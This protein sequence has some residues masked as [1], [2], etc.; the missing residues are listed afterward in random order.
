MFAGVEGRE[1]I[2]RDHLPD[3]RAGGLDLEEHVRGAKVD[4]GLVVAWGKAVPV[5]ELTEMVKLI[6]ENVSD[7]FGDSMLA[8]PEKPC[9]A[10]DIPG[11]DTSIKLGIKGVPVILYRMEHSHYI[12]KLSISVL[13]LKLEVLQHEHLH[14]KFSVS[15]I[16]DP[17]Y[18]LYILF[19]ER[20]ETNSPFCFLDNITEVSSNICGGRYSSI[21]RW[22]KCCAWRVVWGRRFTTVRICHDFLKISYFL[23][24]IMELLFCGYLKGFLSL[25]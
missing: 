6:I 11:G 4:P 9:K 1:I 19:I 3:R 16:V 23:G 17:A 8:V 24:H 7:I 22:V 15:D 14:S 10:I 13:H 21:S 20:L 2:H 5:G 18:F 12:G 25:F